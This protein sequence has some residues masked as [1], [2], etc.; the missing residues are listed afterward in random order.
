MISVLALAACVA[1]FATSS[2]QALRDVAIVVV[3]GFVIRALV[4]RHAAQSGQ[5][6]SSS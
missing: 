5:V 6:R 2:I 4:R 1:L 3:V